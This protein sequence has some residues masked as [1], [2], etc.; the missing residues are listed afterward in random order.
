M[1]NRILDISAIDR[2]TTLTSIA[3]ENGL[4]ISLD[5]LGTSAKQKLNEETWIVQIFDEE[6][7]LLVSGRGQTAVEAVRQVYDNWFNKNL[8]KV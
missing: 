6:E 7:R 4:S 5:L 2:L 3:R 1:S 8:F